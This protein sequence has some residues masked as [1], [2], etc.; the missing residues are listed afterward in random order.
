[1]GFTDFFKKT[2]QKGL[3]YTSISGYG[4]GQLGQLQGAVFTNWQEGEFDDSLPYGYGM[5]FGFSRDPTTL[6][7][8][9]TNT[10]HRKIY[11]H[12][13]FYNTNLS[14]DDIEKMC[15]DRL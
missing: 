5:D 2:V 7:K 6:I 15:K 11:I 4:L 12:E 13:E 3:S 9:A 14:T 10:K 1:M 8:V